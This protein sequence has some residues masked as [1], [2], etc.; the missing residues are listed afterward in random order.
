MNTWKRT[1][2]GLHRWTV[3]GKVRAEIAKSGSVYVGSVYAPGYDNSGRA[4]EGRILRDLK[5]RAEAIWNASARKH[6]EPYQPGDRAILLTETK[7]TVGVVNVLEVFEDGRVTVQLSGPSTQI[8]TDVK[9]LR[10]I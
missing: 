5:T 7:T 6:A 8:T 10:R 9:Y 2:A 4:I 1:P 3:D